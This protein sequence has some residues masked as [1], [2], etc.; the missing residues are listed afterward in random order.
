M[1]KGFANVWTPV[2]LA[3]RLRQS[4]PLP[5]T[6]A[7][8]KL[9]FFR[10]AQ[11]VPYALRDQ[12]PHRGVALSL[13]RITPEGC[14]ECPFHAWQF[15]GSGEVRTVP[16]NPDA[17][18]ERLFAVSIPV[19]EIGGLLWAYTAPTAAPPT[20]PT[21]PDG[22]T[23]P[24]AARTYLE[25][26]WKT[27]WTR[28]MENMLDS[29]H[30]PFLHA[31]TIGRFVRPALKP[32]SRMDISWEETH[33]GG[34]TVSSVDGN[35]TAGAA[36]D[37]FKP[38]MMVL[39]IPIP[40]KVFRMHAFCVPI[41]ETKVRMLIVGTRTFAKLSLLNPIFNRTNAKIAEEDRAI[42]ESSHPVQVPRASEELSVS[43]D[44]ATLQ[45]RKYFF[46]ELYDS[47]AKT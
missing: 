36:L 1:F 39:H 5:I 6:L 16:L 17:K 21:V 4:K 15:S 38:N 31:S 10:D 30:V 13:G 23:M 34:R 33:Y 42:L 28:A 8:E 7:G 37:F 3:K 22:L 9:V 11:G 26:E 44:R 35:D 25:V 29:P 20:E 19:R 24:G 14:L 46:D 45:F 43:T 47:E 2:V 41:D 18:R 27:H 40:G 32:D 12:C